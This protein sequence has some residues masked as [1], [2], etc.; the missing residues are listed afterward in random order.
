MAAARVAAARGKA[1]GARAEAAMAEAAKVA[2]MAVVEVKEALKAACRST[3]SLCLR[4][5]R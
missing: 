5:G 4:P 3:A 2:G 1:A